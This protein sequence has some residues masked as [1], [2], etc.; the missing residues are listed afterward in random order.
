MCSWAAYMTGGFWAIHVGHVCNHRVW[1]TPANRL[2]LSGLKRESNAKA[3]RNMDGPKT[4]ETAAK[5]QRPIRCIYANLLRGE[6]ATKTK[7]TWKQSL[8]KPYKPLFGSQQ[9][10]TSN[11]VLSRAKGVLTNRHQLKAEEICRTR[12]HS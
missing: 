9:K 3:D 10:S 1:P 8:N 12:R 7:K 4:L 11:M 6:V 5:L 2:E